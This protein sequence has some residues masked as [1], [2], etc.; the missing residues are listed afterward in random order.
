MQSLE[1][2]LPR[3][4]LGCTD[5]LHVSH[6]P[7]P[8]LQIML[9]PGVEMSGTTSQAHEC[10]V[11]PQN[12][13]KLAGLHTNCA[14]N[15]G[16]MSATIFVTLQLVQT[17]PHQIEFLVFVLRVNQAECWFH[18]ALKVFREFTTIAKE[19]G[20][21]SVWLL[22]GKPSQPQGMTRKPALRVVS[23]L[24]WR[25][26]VVSGS[27]W[28]SGLLFP[29]LSPCLP[30]LCLSWRQIIDQHHGILSV[31]RNHKWASVCTCT[32]TFSSI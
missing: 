12:M 28:Q 7:Y 5:S 22:W 1:H 30:P 21:W 29:G 27:V 3:F 9:I 15:L 2:V 13:A 18:N 26:V 14:C 19:F 20:V 25:P 32:E 17:C 8:C 10:S 24:P 31:E 23:C 6:T 11:R 4:V 16:L